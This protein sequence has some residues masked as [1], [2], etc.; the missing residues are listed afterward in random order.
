MRLGYEERKM[1][2]D[3]FGVDKLWSYSRLS[4]FLGSPWEYK[5][6][7]ID[8]V[9]R[10]SNIYFDFGNISH[11]TIQG[12]YDG[13]FTYDEM[14][15]EFDKRTLDW[16]MNGKNK[17]MS[18]NVES[19]YI[20]NLRDY[21]Q[22][23][24][25]VPHEVKNEK[26]VCVHII[27]EERDKDIVFIGYVDSE[28]VDEDGVLNIVDYK[29]SS[30]G[31]F[32]GAK[33]KE[34]A[35]QL[36]L[37]AIGINQFRKIPFDKIRLR[38]DMMKYY[39]VEYIQKNGKTA[40][41]KQERCKWVGGM[42]AKL[43]KDLAETGLDPFEVDEIVENAVDTNTLTGIPQEIRDKFTLKNCYIDVMITEEEANAM[44]KFICDV[45]DEID[46]KAKSDDL[47]KAFPE[48]VLCQN[49]RFYF[50]QLASHLL[51][52][53]KGYQEELKMTKPENEVAD[54]DLLALFN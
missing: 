44:K 51:K 21:F 20:K 35:R 36:M 18:E 23:T 42:V 50:T 26:P 2:M 1:I 28:Y 8:K 16:R 47:E 4:C 7:Y 9:E 37:Y 40:V 33:L 32:S 25:V 3:R 29:T 38:F 5:L 27:D 10:G 24:E 34:H 12:F 30:K 14:I 52:Y 6:T 48:P 19:S 53:H 43:R 22:T 41:S 17:F 13:E 46:T 49:N 39:N 45:V 11:S 31:D 54:E 15:E